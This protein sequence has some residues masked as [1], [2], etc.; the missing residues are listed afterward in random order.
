MKT[1]PTPKKAIQSTRRS[2]RVRRPGTS[3]RLSP[4]G[5][6]ALTRGQRIVYEAIAK[7]TGKKVAGDDELLVDIDELYR[8]AHGRRLLKAALIALSDG[9]P[10]PLLVSI[11]LRQSDKVRDLIARLAVPLG[12]YRCPKGDYWANLAGRCPTHKLRLERV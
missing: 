11:Q 12:S 1:K 7:T 3:V 4:S 8:T 2:K 5:P 10:D 6:P 9:P